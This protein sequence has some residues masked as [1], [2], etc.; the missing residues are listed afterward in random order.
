MNSNTYDAFLLVSFGGPEAPEEVM[1]FLD[2]VLRGKPVSEERKKEVAEHYY[3][4]GGVSPINAQNRALMDKL[5]TAF[6]EN[7][8]DLPIYWGNR[9]WK[10]Y[11]LDALTQMKQDGK[12]HALA[13]FTSAYSSYSGCRQYRENIQ[14]AQ[15]QIGEQAPNVSKLRM[16]FNHPHFIQV[17]AN[18]IEDAYAKMNKT[19]KN[20]TFLVFTAH[21]IPI[22]MSENC[23]YE[24]QLHETARLVAQKAGFDHYRLVYQSRSGPPQMPWLEPD[25][26][27]FISSLD[28]KKHDAVL[29]APIGFVSDHME[30]QFDLDVEAKEAAQKKGLNFFRARSAGNDDLFVEMI[31]DLVLERMHD[32]EDKK[33]IGRLGPWHDV[34]PPDCCTYTPRRPVQ[35]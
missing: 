16:F 20:K 28:E 25:V 26:C 1:P 34:C 23:D 33:S 31:V 6:Q 13:Y 2:N 8:I 4:F 18:H 9:N 17:N 21:S 14:A 7:Q 22:A 15:A 35:S 10:P 11:I 19:D 27:D 3:Q 5:Q 24:M 32:R 29:V 30:V 12:R